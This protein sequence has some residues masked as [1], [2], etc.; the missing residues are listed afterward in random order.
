MS[1]SNSQ[2]RVLMI[3]LPVPRLNP[4]ETDF[5][6]PLA[7][8][9]LKAMAYKEGLLDK[10]DIKILDRINTNLSGD[11]RLVKLIVSNNIDL[12]CFSLYP[13]NLLR[14]LF[15]AK[16]V[17][18]CLTCVNVIVGGPEVTPDAQRTLSCPYIDI[19]VIGEGERTFCYLLKHFLYGK[20]SLDKIKGISYKMDKKIIINPPADPIQNL[21][22]IPSPYL[23]GFIDPGE[24]D[25]MWLETMRWCPYRCKYC[26]YHKRSTGKRPSFSVDRIRKELELAKRS[27]VT[28]VVFHDSALNLSKNFEEICQVLREIDPDKS[29]S[30]QVELQAELIDEQVANLLSEVNVKGEVGLQSINPIALANVGRRNNI[31]RFLKGVN[32]LKEKGVDIAVDIMLGLPGDTL[33][34][35]KATLRFLKD[36]DLISNMTFAV[37]SVGPGTDLRKE[38]ASFGIKFQNEPSYRV[39]ETNTL[40]YNELRKALNICIQHFPK[41]DE[42]RSK[43]WRA[44]PSMATYS[45][46]KY[47]FSE[48]RDTEV[49]SGIKFQDIDC[50]IT[51]ISLDLDTSFQQPSQLKHL[52]S[53][54][55]KRVANSLKVFFCCTNIEQ[56][57]ELIKAFLNAISM[58][59]PYSAWNIFFEVNQPFNLKIIDEIESCIEYQISNIDYEWVFLSNQPEPGYTRQTTRFFIILPFL[60]GNVPHQEWINGFPHNT[61]LWWSAQFLEDTDIEKRIDD[62]YGRNGYGILVDFRP[63][64][65]VNFILNTMRLLHSKNKRAKKSV[66]FK[67]WVL[68]RVWDVEFNKS[69]DL[70]GVNEFILSYDKKLKAT[71]TMFQKDELML[72][73]MEWILFCRKLHNGASPT[74]LSGISVERDGN[75]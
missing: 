68:Q 27:G 3:D 47:P 73:I 69:T 63:E 26:Y 60:E 8:G 54:I 19:A 41:I 9:Y 53:T 55:N 39:L 72:D 67:N 36:N 52:A 70:V 58:N 75:C 13:W 20:S 6:A 50:P 11:A 29:I 64:S 35:I 61:H 15:I 71:L 5:F 65:K 46:G 51:R 30:F 4:Q 57:I 43:Y 24:Y 10:V 42:F 12:L 1:N 17:K 40:S 7:S 74:N 66:Q 45:R 21:D 22:E 56:E 62:L 16:K 37:L 44:E 59:N 31:P 48:V 14:S 34:T 33:E 38:A 2:L 25:S 23:L 18:E 28:K 32:L 49:G